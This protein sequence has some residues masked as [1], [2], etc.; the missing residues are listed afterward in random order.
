M[1]ALEGITVTDITTMINGPYCAMLLAEMGAEVIKIEPPD[2]DPWR[3]IGGG[4]LG[5]NRGKRSICID[6]KKERGQKIARDIAAKSDILV[7][8]ARWGVWHKLGMDYASLTEI[9]PDIIYLSILGYGPTGPYSDLP[10]YDPLLQ[11][12]SGQMVGQGGLGEPPVFHV[13]ALNDMAGP[14][15]GAFGIALALLTRIRTGKGQ[16]VQMSLANAAVALQAHRFIDYESMEYEDLGDTG[17]LGLSATH[18]HYK[19]KDNRWI[20]IL[21]SS[22]G[23]WENLCRLMGLEELITDPRFKTEDTRIKNDCALIEILGNAFLEK[24]STEWVA[25]LPQADLPSA[26]GQNIEELM[27]DS[28]SLENNLFDEREHPELGMVKQLSFCPQFSETSGVI[29]RTAPL[30][31]QHTE[32]ILLELDYTGEKIA[33][34]LEDKVVFTREE[35]EI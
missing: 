3:G 24:T 17:L 5:V 35:M 15:L 33:E 8:N 19:T 6:M 28:H 20:Y 16:N 32:E 30:L 26:L 2:G 12:R 18:R 25:A 14:M 22:E 7:E 10:G 21:C 29:R 11:A 9:N 27:T 13:I 31:G 23:H 4:F 1:H 34:L